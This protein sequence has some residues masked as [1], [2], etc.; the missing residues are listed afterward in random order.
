MWLVGGQLVGRQT[1]WPHRLEIGYSVRYL[2]MMHWLRQPDP[3]IQLPIT[4]AQPMLSLWGEGSIASTG[5]LV[6]KSTKSNSHCCSSR[7]SRIHCTAFQLYQIYHMLLLV[8]FSHSTR[9]YISLTSTDHS[10][11]NRN[12]VSISAWSLTL[13]RARP[14]RY[15]EY[16]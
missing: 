8:W 4:V 2:R 9:V 13:E 14:T 16:C 11:R 7:F 15:W 10:N 5:G 6:T 12:P 3:W 1:A